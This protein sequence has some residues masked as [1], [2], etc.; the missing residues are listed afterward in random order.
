MQQCSQKANRESEAL[1][2]GNL[3]KA[4]RCSNLFRLICKQ[5][6]DWTAKT[7][8]Q[9][10]KMFNVPLKTKPRISTFYLTEIQLDSKKTS[11]QFQVV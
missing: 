7:S 9:M 11:S 4:R 10:M 5:W 3:R 2:C 1:L 8:K 6:Y